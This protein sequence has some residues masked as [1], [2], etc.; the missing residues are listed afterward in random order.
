MASVKSFP[1]C[2]KSITELPS[3]FRQALVESLSETED[4]KHLI[5]SPAYS[6]ANFQTLASV[7]CVT[8]QRWLVALCQDDGNVTVSEC[9]YDSTL[10]V[11]LTLILLYGQIKIDFVQDGEARSTALHFNSVMQHL[12]SEAIQYILDAIDG[13]EN[14]TVSSARPGSAIIGGWPLKFRNFSII[15]M[16]KKSRLLDGVC[17]KEM[18]GG[19]GR[20]LAPAAA[21]LVTNRHIV[22]IAEEKTLRWFQF[23]HHSKYG[24][25]MTYF[26]L[27][28]LAD[29]CI[30]PHPRFCILQLEG[31]E[32]HGGEKLDIIFPPDK[33]EEVSRVM[34]KS[35][36]DRAP[37]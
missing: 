25:I 30:E 26:P 35:R 3:P 6:T 14:I 2:A 33:H 31:Y 28:R 8:N 32:G 16:P 18:R 29:F 11:E 34:R 24:A 1:A 21:V 22:V 17:W 20:E 10:L 27:N 13:L 7:L 5:F 12:Y 36:P 23:R 19:F 37:V 9:S 4:L 15:Y